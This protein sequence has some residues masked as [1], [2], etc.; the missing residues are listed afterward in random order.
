MLDP[1]EAAAGLNLFSPVLAAL[2]EFQD[3]IAKAGG[4]VVLAFSESS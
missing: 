2:V 1:D 3:E 4:E